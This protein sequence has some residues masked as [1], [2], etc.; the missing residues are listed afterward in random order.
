VHSQTWDYSSS[1]DE[2]IGRIDFMEAVRHAGSDEE[3]VL[4]C[5]RDMFR[6]PHSYCIGDPVGETVLWEGW[7]R[8]LPYMKQ[9]V[10]Q[11]PGD[12]ASSL[13]YL[14][15]NLS[16][17]YALV[18]VESFML[19]V[20][21]T[22]SDKAAYSALG[23][24]R[25]QGTTASLDGLDEIMRANRGFET[26]AEKE[27]SPGELA[28]R[29]LFQ[30]AEHAADS[31]RWRDILAR[32]KESPSDEDL[33]WAI[34]RFEV[35]RESRKYAAKRGAAFVRTLVP[36]LPQMGLTGKCATIDLLGSVLAA[37]A[38]ADGLALA[39]ELSERRDLG[40]SIFHHAIQLLGHYGG[41]EEYGY[42]T[43][44]LE[45]LRAI[46]KAR[47]LSASEWKELDTLDYAARTYA[48]RTVNPK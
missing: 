10:A 18:D 21:R 2:A 5:C 26:R 22:R 7:Q 28:R 15:A 37:D 9:E 20:A 8:Y 13:L 45:S 41:P 36:R 4:V 25:T 19:D 34:E 43:A 6:G 31:I 38:T 44:R 30:G 40:P 17:A 1:V 12:E 11:R 39:R 23:V 16:R 29:Y 46:K 32:T 24:L 42:L 35:S 27:L 48:H 47:E 33:R 3:V 14:L